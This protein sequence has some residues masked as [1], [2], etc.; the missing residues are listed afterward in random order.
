MT[1]VGNERFVFLHIPKTG[2]SWVS[3]AMA[4]AGIELD[5]L[6][7]HPQGAEV[8]IG[9]RFTFAFVREP[10]SWF[11][12]AWKFHRRVSLSHWPTINDWIDLDFPGFV[13]GMVVSSPGYLSE[14]FR[15]FIGPPEDQIDFVGRYEQLAD[16]LVTA[17][18]SAGQDFDEDALRA[19]P[20][21]NRSLNQD[22]P[23]DTATTAC[24]AAT[25]RRLH[26]SEREIY[27]RFYEAATL[28]ENRQARRTRDKTTPGPPRRRRASAEMGSTR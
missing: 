26:Q 11:G 17:L 24:P 14:Y 25:V 21:V 23:L 9:G 8:E 10:L 18:R 15:A 22:N 2:G 19:M 20:R 1:A 27:T 7:A 13:D 5:E 12:S 4:N 6:G 3:Q 16:D 28:I